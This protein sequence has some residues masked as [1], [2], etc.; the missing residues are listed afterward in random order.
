MSSTQTKHNPKTS[1]FFSSESSRL[2]VLLLVGVCFAF[3]SE[4]LLRTFAVPDYLVPKPSQVLTVLRDDFSLLMEHF[5]YTSAEWAIGLILSVLFALILAV[6]CFFSSALEK[7]VHPILVISQSV[8]YLVFAP[9]L[10]IWLGLGMAPKV[11]L[12]VLTCVFPIASG[13]L[14]GLRAAKQ[15]YAVVVAMLRFSPLKAFA[16][17]Y[18]PASLSYFFTGLRM[19]VTYA[20]VSAVLAELIGSEKGLGVYIIR[21]QNSYRIDKVLAAVLIV[22]AASLVTAALTARLQ[23]KIVFWKTERK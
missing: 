9:V 5:W 22:V 1:R 21:A 11:V 3:V 19:S 13:V 20:F 15:E 6:L 7:L 18:F 14:D 16:N 10:L 23:H 8:P 12:I 4:L 2:I 17:V